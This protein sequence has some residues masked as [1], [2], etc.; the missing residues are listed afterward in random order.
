MAMCT[1]WPDAASAAARV[2]GL[3]ECR[4]GSCTA[5]AVSI[6]VTRLNCTAAATILPNCRVLC[7]GTP[8]AGTLLHVWGL[9]APPVANQQFV[10]GGGALRSLFARA[11][12]GRRVG[13]PYHARA[14]L[15]LAARRVP[16]QLH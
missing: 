3:A 11:V 12:R 14:L 7:C 10:F 15:W 9:Y 1:N 16:L 6:V 8:Q 2:C 13:G 5:E 4:F